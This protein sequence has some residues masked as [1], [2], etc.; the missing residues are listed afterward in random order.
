MAAA[1][2]TQ[3]ATVPQWAAQLAVSV[4]RIET[5]TDQIPKLVEDFE[6]LRQN[7]VPLSEHA[8]LMQRVEEL[9]NRDLQG[10]EAWNQ[11][12]PRVATLWQERDQEQGARTAHRVWLGV[13]SVIVGVLTVFTLLRDLGFSAS[14]HP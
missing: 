9:W 7:T 3:E 13:L 5:R 10:R 14:F 6:R 8:Q 11:M 2:A 4:A 1:D 12:I